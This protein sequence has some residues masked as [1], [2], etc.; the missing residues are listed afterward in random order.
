MEQRD[1]YEILGVP[2]HASEKQIKAAYRKLAFQYHPDRN[3]RDPDSANK[4]KAVNEAYAVLSNPSKR[5]DYDD[6]RRQYG[7]SAYNRFRNN[8]TDNDIFRGSDINRIFEEMARAF[9]FRG[10]DDIFNEAYGEGYRTFEFKRPGFS[11]RGFVFTGPLRRSAQ[12]ET[13]PF[14][15]GKLS[16]FL[17]EKITGVEL[18]QP[19]ADV[20]ETIDLTLREAEEGGP[21]PYDYKKKSKKLVVMLPKG[22][23]EGQRIRL[24][25]MGEDGKGGAKA[26]DLYLT[27]RINKP[28]MQRLKDWLHS[29][30]SVAAR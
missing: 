19:G 24:A 18:P 26:G 16:R 3:T 9:G 30:R 17:I 25:G 20:A 13:S 11:V 5:K 10:F 4:M 28:L 22:L 15:I 7:S 21:Y 12:P 8:Y 6:L 27:V 29:A 23:R 2:S 1:Y 14:A